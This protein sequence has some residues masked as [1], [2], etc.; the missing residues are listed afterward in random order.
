MIFD[1]DFKYFMNADFKIPKGFDALK[2]ESITNKST[3]IGS[4][5]DIINNRNIVYS[6][7]CGIIGFGAYIVN[8][9]G[10]QKIVDRLPSL[11]EYITDIAIFRHS[12]V[13]CTCVMPSHTLRDSKVKVL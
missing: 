8:N 3:M 5:I 7:N 10:A 2:H 12:L 6:L 4:K 9:V 1:N 13:E 11:G